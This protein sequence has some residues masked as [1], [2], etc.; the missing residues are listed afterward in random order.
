MFCPRCSQQQPSDEVR[1]CPRCGFPLAGVA[2]LIAG[3]DVTVPNVDAARV[4]GQVAKRIGIRR[5][6]KFMFFSLAFTPI[7][8]G[9]CFLFN[10]PVFLF[11]PITLFL[12]GVLWMLYSALFGEEILPVRG[13]AVRAGRGDPGLDALNFPPASYFTQRRVNPPEIAPPQSVTEN[14][15]KLLDKDV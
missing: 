2:A 12:A 13:L 11:V 1:F 10:T 5:G 7:F 6:A 14:T 9:L 3:N 4:P 15:T 8:L